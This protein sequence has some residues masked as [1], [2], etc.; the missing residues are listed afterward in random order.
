[1]FAGICSKEQADKMVKVL[2]DEKR[3][4]T[5][6]PVPSMPKD[7]EAYDIDMWRGCSWLN[8]NYFTMLGLL[9]YGY[10]DIADELRERTLKTV[11]KWY[12]KTGN[13]FEF[14]DAD[15]EICPF[16]LKIKGEQPEK[17][18]YRAHIHSITDYNWSSCFTLMFIQNIY[19]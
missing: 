10:T 11:L 7:S 8:L 1:M 2:L 19:Y 17:T 5:A 13:V 9:K 12:E 14:Y 6:M 15:D 16:R 4:W 18:D 3:F